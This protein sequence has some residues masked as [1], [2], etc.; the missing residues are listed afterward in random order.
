MNVSNIAVCFNID[1]NVVAKGRRAADDG[2]LQHRHGPA[3]SCWPSSGPTVP[4]TGGAQTVT[5]SGAGLTWT[6]VSRANA[7]SGDAEIWQAT[8]A[9]PAVRR[10]R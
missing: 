6:L 9:E 10:A 8:A 5:V 1:V 4:T 2:R 3:S 7:S